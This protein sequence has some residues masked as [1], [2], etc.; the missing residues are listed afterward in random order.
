M[1]FPLPPP[2]PDRDDSARVR[3]S[4]YVP[5]TT[6]REL[7]QLP[8]TQAWQDE[9]P[10]DGT[11]EAGDPDFAGL[12]VAGR[13]PAVDAGGDGARRRDPRVAPAREIDGGGLVE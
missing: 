2:E 13:K 11:T 10:D 9:A 5:D 8:Q 6:A 4:E 7:P 12:L 3:M 1:H